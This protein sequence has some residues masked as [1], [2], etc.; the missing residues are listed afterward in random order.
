MMDYLRPVSQK[1]RRA[2]VV[3]LVAVSVVAG[4]LTIAV[5][6]D[7]LSRGSLEFEGKP[8]WDIAIVFATLGLIAAWIAWRVS[9]DRICAN[10]ATNIPAWFIRLFGALV[11]VGGCIVSFSE[12]KP[13]LLIV[14]MLSIPATLA[15]LYV[16]RKDGE[17]KD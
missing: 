15:M 7:M 1:V 4:L 2:S 16:P 14:M 6:A 3:G 11:L 13:W 5:C 12:H 8:I 10:G 9:H 17:K